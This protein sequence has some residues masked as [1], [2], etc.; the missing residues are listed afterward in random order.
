MEQRILIPRDIY[1]PFGIKPND[2]SYWVRS[3]I[4]QADVQ[5]S[6]GQGAANLFSA[7]QAIRAGFFQYFK[8]SGLTIETSEQIINMLFND[9]QWLEALCYPEQ[10]GFDLWLVTSGKTPLAVCR[11]DWD[12]IFK[13]IVRTRPVFDEKNSFRLKRNSEGTPIEEAYTIPAPYERSDF[14]N[15]K[16]FDDEVSLYVPRAIIRNAKDISGIAFYNITDIF[17][18]AVN[19]LQIN[20]ERDITLPDKESTEEHYAEIVNKSP[21]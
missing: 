9:R 4:I 18:R 14:F 16:L 13:D 19:L 12:D 20:V 21:R 7:I 10:S 17:T 8:N 2:F 5:P 3:G 1:K 6:P 11:T 15:F